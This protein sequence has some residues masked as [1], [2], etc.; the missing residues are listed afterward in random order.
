MTD[1]SE[2]S[3]SRAPS[4]RDVARLAGVSRQTVSRVINGEPYIKASTEAHVREVIAELAWRPNS[5]ARALAT[6]RSK[7]IGLL[8]SERSQY[9][10]FSASG[11]IDEAARERGYTINSATLA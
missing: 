10:P 2:V 3:T 9:G 1:E 6:S 8:V 7:S 5:A 11:A 4:I